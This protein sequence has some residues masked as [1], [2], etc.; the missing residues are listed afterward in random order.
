MRQPVYLL[1]APGM[2]ATRPGE[3]PGSEQRVGQPARRSSF[4]GGKK[5]VAPLT[6]KAKRLGA[7]APRVAPLRLANR[8][9][10]PT[11]RQP[12]RALLP[13]HLRAKLRESDI[14]VP[15][16][17]TR[18]VMEIL[19]VLRQQVAEEVSLEFSHILDE[20]LAEAERRGEKIIEE[21]ALPSRESPSYIS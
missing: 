15:V 3:A 14:D 6:P 16:F 21:L 11:M 1:A 13:V 2:A 4:F 7:G 17:T 18:D 20:R 9:T 10:C 5:A 12:L 8:Y 19:E